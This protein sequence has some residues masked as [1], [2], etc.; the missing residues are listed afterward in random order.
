MMSDAKQRDHE[1][2]ITSQGKEYLRINS[3]DYKVEKLSALIYIEMKLEGVVTDAG[4]EKSPHIHPEIRRGKCVVS[5][6]RDQLSN[7]MPGNILYK[8]VR[9]AVS[10]NYD[11][12]ANMPKNYVLKKVV[13]TTNFV[14]EEALVAAIKHGAIA[15]DGV[16][17]PTNG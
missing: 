3:K 4:G 1:Y 8:R 11:V 9:L 15:L 13:E 2:Q 10:C 16:T 12:S 7:D 5:A 6:T 17:P 14:D